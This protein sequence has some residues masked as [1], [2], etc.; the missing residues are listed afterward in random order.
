MHI[1][2]ARHVGDIL[3]VPAENGKELLQ[4]LLAS[5]VKGE[6]L[7]LFHR[8]PGLVDTM[9]GVARRIGRSRPEVEADVK[10]FLDMGLLKSI[11]AGK[12]S[13]VSFNVE[14]DKEVQASLA[15]YLRRAVK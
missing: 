10:D 9:D 6:L 11:Q 13:L 4:R 2:A 5:E 7:T 8:N 14:K 15:E 1:T 12:M 3:S